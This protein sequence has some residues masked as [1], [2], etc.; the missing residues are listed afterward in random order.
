MLLHQFNRIVAGDSCPS[1]VQFEGD[2]LG[3]RELQKLFVWRDAVDGFKLVDMVVIAELDAGFRCP[4]TESV[5]SLHVVAPV[6]Q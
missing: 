6:I 2:L 3:I 4:V 1:A 5:E